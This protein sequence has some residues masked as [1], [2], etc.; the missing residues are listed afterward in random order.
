M[1]DWLD[2]D[3]LWRDAPCTCR[4][5]YVKSCPLHVQ[6]RCAHG[7]VRVVERDLQPHRRVRLRYLC[8]D[9]GFEYHALGL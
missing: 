7:T 8:L 6:R 3:R 2:R 1:D 5:S 4:S 9:C